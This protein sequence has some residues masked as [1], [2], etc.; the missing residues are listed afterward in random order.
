M[1]SVNGEEGG[2]TPGL[3]A[4]SAACQE[5]V[6]AAYGFDPVSIRVDSRNEVAESAEDNNT[7]TG[8]LPLP[9]PPILCT[10]TPAA[11]AGD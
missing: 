2:R 11:T 6:P 1:V 4:G 9:T 7:W 8:I 3:S 5:T 10:P